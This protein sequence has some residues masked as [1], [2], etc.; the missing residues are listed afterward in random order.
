M[1]NIGIGTVLWTMYGKEQ[2]DIYKWYAKPRCVEKIDNQKILFGDG[3]GGSLNNIGKNWFLT[4]QEAIDNFLTKHDSLEMRMPD[5]TEDEELHT[6]HLARTDYQDVEVVKFDTVNQTSVYIGFFYELENVT[7]ILKW[8][9]EYV[10]ALYMDLETLSLTEIYEQLKE[11]NEAHIITVFVDSPLN[12]VIYQCGNHEK[13][14]WEQIGTTVG[15][16]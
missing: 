15:Y 12:G 13:G 1:A 11:S 2:N 5:I 16:A 4:R 8:H 14:K 7:D 10:D 6:T 3:T 9:K